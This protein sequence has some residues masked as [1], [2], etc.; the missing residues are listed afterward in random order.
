[1]FTPR[2]AVTLLFLCSV[3]CNAARAQDG[4]AAAW[5]GAGPHAV[6]T[7]SFDWRDDQ[8]Q[9]DV[10]VKVYLPTGRAP[11]AGWPLIVFSHGL[12]GSRDGYEYVGRRWASH[13]YVVIHP[14][15][16]GSDEAVWRGKPP[17]QVNAALL[18][19]VRDPRNALERPRDVS[20][21]IDR[22]L[23]MNG[24]A[25]W[26]SINPDRIGVG[27]HSFGAFTALATVGASA[28]TP[29]GR[30]SLRDPRIKAAVAM[31]A[32]VAPRQKDDREAF[33]SV[34]VPVLHMTG[35]SDNSAIGDTPAADRRVPFDQATKAPAYL[36]TFR[37][38]G[39]DHM[40]FS[41]RRWR[42][43]AQSTDARYQSLIL[44]TTTAFWDAHLRDNAD[45]RAFLAGDA[46]RSV[47]DPAARYEVKPAPALNPR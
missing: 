22:A 3:C 13:G 45:A 20:F 46:A 7:A 12:G 27:G 44:L 30:L 8:R 34:A 35:D 33:G 4:G 29:M 47:L 11:E 25:P 9:R 40:V 28:Q 21:V 42:G 2:L 32:P 15:H 5:S 36:V 14:Q 16:A 39:G 17:A 41:G 31:S 24:N 1:M 37:G 10:P 38:R 18:A 6:R 23:G 26:G 43:P 19:A